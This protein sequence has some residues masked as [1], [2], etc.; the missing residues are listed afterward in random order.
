MGHAYLTSMTGL[1]LS[2]TLSYLPKDLENVTRTKTLRGT[3]WN[4]SSLLHAI[5]PSQNARSR[6]L[7]P[8]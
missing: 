2:Q 3:E 4:V 1:Q 5:E 6:G 8:C 7:R